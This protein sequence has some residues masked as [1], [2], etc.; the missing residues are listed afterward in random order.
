MPMI[1]IR[2]ID[3]SG[4]DVAKRAS[5]LRQLLLAIAYELRTI[6]ETQLRQLSRQDLGQIVERIGR[7]TKNRDPPRIH[8]IAAGSKPPAPQRRNQP[9]LNEG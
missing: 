8:P 4:D 2:G 6:L 1:L 3:E 7:R 5:A 9:G